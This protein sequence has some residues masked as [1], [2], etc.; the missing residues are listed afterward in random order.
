MDL[1]A[2]RRDLRPNELFNQGFNS[3]LNDCQKIVEDK[4][5]NEAKLFKGLKKHLGKKLVEIKEKNKALLDLQRKANE[6]EERLLE[7]QQETSKVSNLK[8]KVKG[9]EEVVS[10]QDSTL[11]TY[12]EALMVYQRDL[13]HWKA[14][15]M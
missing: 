10:S 1:H 8:A 5:A 3:I 4:A 14:T 11:T 7:L 15:A 6:G 2:R 12:D 13:E 9:L